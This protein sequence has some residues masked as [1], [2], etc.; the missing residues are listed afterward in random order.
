[1]N[2]TTLLIIIVPALILFL[3][4][5]L[6]AR[7]LHRKLQETRQQAERE[8][9]LS[10]SLMLDFTRESKSL[11]RVEVPDPV[12]HILCVD[13]E[14]VILDSFRKILVLDGYSVDTVETGQEALGLVQSHDYDFV[15]TD[16]KMPHM[17][18]TDVAKSVKHLRPDIDVV[19]ITGFATVESAVE[20]MKHGAMDYVE[21]PFTEDELRTFTR[22]ALIK[23]QD[24][25]EKQLKPRVHVLGASKKERGLGREFYVP[26]GVLISDGHCWASLAEDGTARVGLDDF[27]KKL[28]GRIDSI[29]MPEI[30][31]HARIGDILF[32]INQ[33]GRLADFRAPLSGKVVR[34]NEAVRSDCTALDES[35]YGENWICVIEGD[36]L[37]AELAS[38]KIGRSAVAFIQEE[39][40]RFRKFLNQEDRESAADPATFCIGAFESLDDSRWAAAA[41][42]FFGR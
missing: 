5:N 3:F 28:L 13:D 30:G 22:H 14:E 9:V 38:S 40:D 31:L 35:S 4:L 33:D 8:K 7:E 17:S 12:A 23:R 41:T 2:L 11:K 36:N 20:C 26:G 32:S 15:F 29:E 42:Q 10:E 19:I 21:K 6:V 27:A 16:L 34:V 37:D 24:R 1:M 39:I 25:L 18:G